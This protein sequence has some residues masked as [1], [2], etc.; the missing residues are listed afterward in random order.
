MNKENKTSCFPQ[1]GSS[2]EK[3]VNTLTKRKVNDAACNNGKTFGYL[4]QPDEEASRLLKEVYDLFFF[5]NAL[6]FTL[7]PSLIAFENETVAMIRDLLNGTTAV[8]GNI[9]SGGTESILMAAKAAR[10]SA[11]I[12]HPEN[13]SPE[14]LLPLSV[15][16]AFYKAAHYLGLRTVTVPLQ[17]DYRADIDVL[18]SRI[19]KNTIMIVG[20]APSFPHGTIDPLLEMGEIAM[21]HDLW[22]HIDACLGG[23]ML[24]FV[25]KLGY[26]VAPFDFRVPGVTSLSADIHKYG[27]GAKGASVILYKNKELRKHQFFVKGDW[28]GGFFGS[29][30]LLGTR[31]GGP[32]VAAWAMLKYMGLEGY[33][34]LAARTMEA[35]KK[36]Q[37]GVQSIP[38]LQ[39]A[40]DPLM[41]VFAFTSAKGNIYDIGDALSARGWYLDRIMTPEA[42]HINMTYRNIDKTDE[43]LS[44]LS[45]VALDHPVPFSRK[46][47]GKIAQVIGT[48]MLTSFPKSAT[49]KIGTAAARGLM[50]TD[51]N[52]ARPSA[53]LY[54]IAA[55]QTDTKNIS[56]IIYD[57]L[58][59][60][61]Q[62]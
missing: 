11:R 40:G 7:C 31:S 53:P 44:D 19:N 32:V 21:E 17:K 59:K 24:P 54:G 34:K 6:N 5:Y 42:L 45:A 30:A 22:F 18:K 51:E 9:T 14:V 52:K 35:T 46:V 62:I 28:P 16:P 50:K 25:E 41:S 8:C 13:T 39:I 60:I 3:I 4:Y 58:D 61:F 20:S 26:R 49:V 56:A 10:D 55:K 29:P 43:F 38:G 48:H 36:I 12:A 47:A 57:F 23:M 15:H 37:A 33:I 2:R 27:Y 1:R